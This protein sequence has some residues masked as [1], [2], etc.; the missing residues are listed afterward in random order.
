MDLQK[1]FD[2]AMQI[3]DFTAAEKLQVFVR[4][5]ITIFTPFDLP[6]FHLGNN[7]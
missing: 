7:F 1:E 2:T 4:K 6:F 3:D 5:N